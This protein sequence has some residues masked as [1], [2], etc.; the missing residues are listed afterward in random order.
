MEVSHSDKA[1]S[2]SDF[3]AQ[4]RRSNRVYNPVQLRLT[5]RFGL[6][7]AR[8]STRLRYVDSPFALLVRGPS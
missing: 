6:Y 1:V 2:L 4:D 5:R 8:Q 3:R 7:T